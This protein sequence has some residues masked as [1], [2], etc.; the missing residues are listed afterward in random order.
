M[1]VMPNVR[2][3]FKP[4]PGM[5]MFEADLKGA[6]AQI[7]AWEADDESLKEIF[8]SGQDLHLANAR[9]IFPTPLWDEVPPN[10]VKGHPILGAFR[11]KA[12]GGVH[13][14]NYG[15]RPPTLARALQ[16]TVPEA[17]VFQQRWFAL[18]PGV[19]NWQKRIWEQLQ[20]NRTVTN[21]FGYRRQYFGR[22]DTIL[23]EALAWGP[24]S[25]VALTINRGIINMVKH[26]PFVQPLLQVHDSIVGQYP[27]ALGLSFAKE[28][29][30]P[31]L[32]ITL[33]YADPLKIP[34]SIGTSTVSWGDIH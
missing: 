30:R 22:L 4:D 24:Q 31:A 12:K 15:A 17:E 29:L 32:E 26:F 18:H 21:I 3:E 9:A 13:A 11:Q 1:I 27:E 34:V 7:V 14:T 23:P 5:I 10:E 16:I 33:P 28:Q 6:D 19:E 2:K 20:I 8:R 25:T